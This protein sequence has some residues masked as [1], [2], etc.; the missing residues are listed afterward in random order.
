MLVY[1]LLIIDARQLRRRYKFSSLYG[2]A[3]EEGR[4]LAAQVLHHCDFKSG[5]STSGPIFLLR[6]IIEKYS[7]NKITVHGELSIYEAW[8]FF[9]KYR[10]EV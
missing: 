5:R 8:F 10:F 6:S 2:N 4:L 3:S 7:E 1:I 9:C